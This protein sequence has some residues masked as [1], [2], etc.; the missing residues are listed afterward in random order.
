[1][2]V[3]EV[4]AAAELRG[5]FLESVLVQM[6]EHG[7]AMASEELDVFTGGTRA[8]VEAMVALHDRGLIE[9]PD[10]EGGTLTPFGERTATRIKESLLSGPRRA[11][12][13]QRALLGW[14]NGRSTA[15]PSAIDEFLALPEA[16]ASGVPMTALEVQHAAELL[17]DRQFISV[18]E[19]DQAEVL[20]QPRITAD[21]RSA[22]MSDVLITDY[23]KANPTMIS[24]DYSSSIS[25]GNNAV[26]GGVIA[27]GKG[28]QQNVV[29]MVSPAE[30]TELATRVDALLELAAQLPEG[31]DADELREVLGSLST[32]V[33]LAEPR[34]QVVKDLVIKAVGAVVGVVGTAAG[35]QLLDGIGQLAQ[36]L[37]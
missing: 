36:M 20:L 24:N 25:F 28:H 16:V 27:G 17:R 26:A 2:E 15:G 23:G 29:Q 22:F 37:S 31:A 21:G 34:R 1:M 7:G 4:Q 8:T 9:V 14:L 32:E 11:D 13:V 19:V 3:N 30:K 5:S 12:A 6:N 10:S 18:V 33:E 35:Q